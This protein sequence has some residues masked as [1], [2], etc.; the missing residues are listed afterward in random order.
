ML[1]GGTKGV[2]EYGNFYLVL[3]QELEA[4]YGPLDAETISSIVG[5]SAGGP[6]SLSKKG[7]KRLFVTC[8][9]AAY[10]EQKKSSE[11]INYELLSIG[12]FS[13]EWCKNVFTA[14][15]NLSMNAVLGDNHTID[16]SGVVEPGDTVKQVRLT[17]F[18][19]TKH[20]GK[21]YGI[22]RVV[23]CLVHKTAV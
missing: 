23:P 13:E 5:F 17:L 14:L 22:Y 6:V 12:D 7:A 2:M 3:F 19:R 16:V 11:G 20:K 21:D 9:L 4:K 10:Q 8:E 15:G 18:S 1:D